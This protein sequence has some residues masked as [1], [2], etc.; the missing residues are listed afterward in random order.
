MARHFRHRQCLVCPTW[1]TPKS[2]T[3]KYCPVCAPEQLRESARLYSRAKRRGQPSPH[4][5]ARLKLDDALERKLSEFWEA[6][7]GSYV[8]EPPGP[9]RRSTI[10]D[11]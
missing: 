8:P 1:Y 9:Y 2:S 11:I 6:R 7:Y 10:C 3:E 4:A 5:D